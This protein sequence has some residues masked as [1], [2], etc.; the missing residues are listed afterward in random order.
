MRLQLVLCHAAVLVLVTAAPASAAQAA[1]EAHTAEVNGIQMHYEVV[2]AGDPLLLLH[3]G[4]QS[5]RMWDD[6]VDRFSE[7]NRLII[8]DL[9]GHGRSTNPDGVW[10][11]SQLAADVFALLDILE[12][13]RVKAIG[14]SIGAMTLLRMATQQPDRIDAMIVIGAGTYIP[15]ECRTILASATTDTLSEAAWQQL[16]ATHPQGDD[17]I[18]ALYA[19]VASLAGSVDDMN[20]TPPFL[21][22]ITARTLI[23]HGDRDYCFPA[24]MAWDMYQAIPDAELWVVPNGSH[25]PIR[26]GNAGFFAEIAMGF[27]GAAGSTE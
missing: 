17:Q 3:S 6:F 22:T 25:V 7:H 1:V 9:R 10:T 21:A 13:D 18:R 24:S 27:L 14:A 12:L 8:P 23:I 26:D 20:F 16:R 2:G 19:W 5:S 15:A 4:T 11:T